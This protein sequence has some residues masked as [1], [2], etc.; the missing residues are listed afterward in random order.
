MDG[1]SVRLRLIGPRGNRAVRTCHSREEP[2]RPPS[3]PYVLPGPRLVCF[4]SFVGGV[5]KTTLAV[6]TATFIATRLSIERRRRDM[7]V[8]ALVIDAAR[9]SAPVGLRL[10]IH[11]DELSRARTT[12]TGPSRRRARRSRANSHGSI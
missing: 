8:R 7:P 10:G 9:M 2:E 6:E 1:T 12:A 4:L 5:G 11:P 3:I